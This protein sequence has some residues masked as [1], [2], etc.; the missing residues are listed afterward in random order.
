MT[1][2]TTSTA[3]D[4]IAELT[5]AQVMVGAGVVDGSSSVIWIEQLPEDVAEADSRTV[6][7]LALGLRMIGVEVPTE[8]SVVT[9]AMVAV[10][11]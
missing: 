5:A 8:E 6:V 2:P 3:E 7:D 9:C 1:P 11:C 10:L 4:E